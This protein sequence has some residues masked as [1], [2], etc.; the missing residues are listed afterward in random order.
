MG[1]RNSFEASILQ[2]PVPGPRTTRLIVSVDGTKTSLQVEPS[3][4]VTLERGDRIRFS[5]RLKRPVHYQ[6][7][8][9]FDYRRFLERQGILL[10]GYVKEGDLEVIAKGGGEAGSFVRMVDRVRRGIGILL[11]RNLGEAETGF[12]KALLTGDRSGLST[13]T[14][15]SFRRTGTAHL[16]AISGQ[17]IGMVGIASFAIFLWLLKR[18]RRLLLTLS[19]RKAALVLA[20]VPIL[21][22]TVLA[23]SPPSAMRAALLATL[24]VLAVLS[25]RDLDPLSALAAAAIIIPILDL[26][27]PFSAS[28]QLSFLAVLGIL[29]FRRRADAGESGLLRKYVA[30]PLWMTLGAT[31]A[32]AP[33]VAYL[34]HRVSLSG[35]LS[36][37]WAIPCV[38]LILITG[39]ISVALAMIFTPL[40]SMI[41]APVGLLARLFLRFLH[42][43]SE[44]SWVVSFYPTEAELFLCLVGVALVV[45]IRRRPGSWKQV[46]A[47]GGGLALI[48]LLTVGIGPLRL[49]QREF[50]VT[51]LDVGEGDAALVTTPAG[52]SLL[53]DGGGFLV[54]EKREKREGRFDVGTEV[55]V[56]YLKRLGIRRIDT[57][58]LSHPHPD[59]YGG[60]IAVLDAF[61]V[62]EFWWN[63]ES[64]PDESFDRLL[65]RIRSK[66]VPLRI[67]RD[68]DLLPWDEGTVEVLYPDRIDRTRK[69]NDNSLVVLLDLA[70]VGILF[71]GDIE[72]EGEKYLQERQAPAIAILKIP[73]HGS[74]TSSSVPFID[75]ARPRFAIASLGE[76]NMFG[77]PHEGVL[78]KY[79]RRG[80]DLY[81]T[82]RDGAVI[83]AWPRDSSGHSISI[84][85]TGKPR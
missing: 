45:W 25:G 66:E 65:D 21:F 32:T 39:G 8:G 34:F 55:V 13:E 48:A 10:S 79:E 5:A 68:G 20:L 62:G 19:V 3:E 60:L 82:D 59:H 76:K 12:L 69:I 50:R 73:H 80:V 51:F 1:K 22:Y 38:G 9:G 41:L 14:W 24:V 40:A 11:E 74:R 54:P 81:R 75:W 4:A 78:E 63:G 56:P 16:V 85:T 30:N 28:F 29:L 6:N 83:F 84:Q 37:L 70:G 64:F 27:A 52:K 18:S 58:L 15:E 23:G 47:C 72:K 43:F 44:H 31:L 61:E 46:A 2:S 36:N 7:P 17:H 71:S 67:L 35:L 49:S 42:L 26:A 77:F 53:V 33:L 57:V